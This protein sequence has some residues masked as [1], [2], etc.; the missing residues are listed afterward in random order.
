[1]WYWF[2]CLPALVKDLFV[3]ILLICELVAAFKFYPKGLVYHNSNFSQSRGDH[4]QF[5]Q[6]K[7]AQFCSQ[8]SN[9][10]DQGSE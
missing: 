4:T 10:R 8:D 2:D 7:E 6:L 9:V 1:M 3:S 5:Y